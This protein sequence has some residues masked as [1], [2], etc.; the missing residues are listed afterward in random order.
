MVFQQFEDQVHV[1]VR[2]VTQRLVDM[3]T[4]PDLE[5]TAEVPQ[6]QPFEVIRGVAAET[7]RSD[8]RPAGKPVPSHHEVMVDVPAV[9]TAEQQVERPVILTDEV[10]IP[11][12]EQQSMES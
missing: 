3:P 6:F 9:M 5:V 7:N 4:R 1:P 8:E 2:Q 12:A 11:R 10:L